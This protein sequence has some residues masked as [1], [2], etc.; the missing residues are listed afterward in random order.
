MVKCEARLALRI[1]LDCDDARGVRRQRR[2]E[3]RGK[4]HFRHALKHAL[5]ARVLPDGAHKEYAVP[6][7]RRMGGKV[8]GRSTQ[9]FLI[10]DHIPQ[11]FTDADD[12]HGT[13][14]R[15]SPTRIF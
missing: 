1:E 15:L 2:N 8:E 11:D 13:A 7:P 6:E 5:P 9:V 4:A 10:L 14:S 12:S 3:T